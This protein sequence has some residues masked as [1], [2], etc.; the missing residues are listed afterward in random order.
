M[1]LKFK[2]ISAYR[3]LLVQ[4]GETWPQKD[5]RVSRTPLLMV[6][7]FDPI[8]RLYSRL[9]ATAI[10]N[11]RGLPSGHKFI[12]SAWHWF[13]GLRLCCQRAGA[14][15]R[16]MMPKKLHNVRQL[17]ESPLHNQLA[18]EVNDWYFCQRKHAWRPSGGMNLL[19]FFSLA[20]IVVHVAFDSHKIPFPEIFF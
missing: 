10:T 17:A 2:T 1:P 20:L 15:R 6:K 18:P 5:L 3:L 13:L 19:L 12:T 4:V 16:R 9:V 14:F 8:D 7:R 11:K